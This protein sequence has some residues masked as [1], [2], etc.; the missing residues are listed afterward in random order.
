L[1]RDRERE[2]ERKKERKKVREIGERYDLPFDGFNSTLHQGGSLG[3]EPK[4]VHE[5]LHVIEFYRL[6]LQK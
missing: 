1:R 6:S 5:L 3:I 4:L 2:R